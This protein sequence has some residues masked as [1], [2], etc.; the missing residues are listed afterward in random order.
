MA[1][2]PCPECDKD[3]SDLATT[4]PHCGRPLVAETRVAPTVDPPSVE[5]AKAPKQSH[6]WKKYLLVLLIGGPVVFIG[7]AFIGGLVTGY[8]DFIAPGHQ[9]ASAEK[10]SVKGWREVEE[11]KTGPGYSIHVQ[12]TYEDVLNILPKSV[13]VPVKE[14]PD[15]DIP[16]SLIMDK[17]FVL[18]DGRKVLL[19]ISRWYRLDGPYR[20]R[21][22]HVLE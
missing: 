14:F 3:V 17:G 7:G 8:R 2:V 5:K 19:T 11:L 4:C 18:R 1:L 9:D 21:A 13:I 10:S 22:I 6:S 20:V 16:G 12:D 15:P